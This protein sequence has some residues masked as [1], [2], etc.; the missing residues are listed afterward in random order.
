MCSP[1]ILFLKF[2]ILCICFLKYLPLV[3]ILKKMICLV[4]LIIS[5]VTK[6]LLFLW[7]AVIAVRYHKIPVNFLVDYILRY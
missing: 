7:F 3:R 1:H 5:G 4:I 2:K 6:V